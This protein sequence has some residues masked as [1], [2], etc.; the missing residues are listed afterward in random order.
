[1]ELKRETILAKWFESSS[2]KI[3]LLLQNNLFEKID[4][5][6]EATNYYVVLK[7]S[8]KK[9]INNDNNFL[10]KTEKEAINAI[11]NFIHNNSYEI[12]LIIIKENKELQEY[13]CNCFKN[14]NFSMIFEFITLIR[15][16]FFEVKLIKNTKFNWEIINE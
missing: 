11:T 15:E 4:K 10:F 3:K 6:S 13:Y 16:S 1:M 12:M 9:F 5:L 7:G 2:S 8:N 14:N